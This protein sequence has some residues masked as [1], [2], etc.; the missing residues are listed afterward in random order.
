MPVLTI[1][2]TLT[3]GDEGDTQMNRLDVTQALDQKCF[4]QAE[5]GSGDTVILEGRI[6]ATCSFVTIGQ[7]YT[8]N[9]LR[10]VNLPNEYRAVRTIDGGSEDSVVILETF[11]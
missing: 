11:D 4:L 2:N 5:I 6:D 7:P 10:R 8:T 1:L 3:D 9:T